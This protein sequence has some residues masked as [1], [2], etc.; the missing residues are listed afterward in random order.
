MFN[1][2]SDGAGRSLSARLYILILKHFVYRD[3]R[4]L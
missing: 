3:L 4:M 1:N 2:P